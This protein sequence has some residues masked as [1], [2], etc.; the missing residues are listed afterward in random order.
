MMKGVRI[1]FC[2]LLLALRL[3][4]R[5]FANSPQRR[6]LSDL[7]GQRGR[8]AHYRA[9]AKMAGLS[10][11]AGTS[12]SLQVWIRSLRTSVDWTEAPSS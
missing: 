7:Q 9:A 11:L 2:Q 10:R 12:Q 1:D 6:I 8:P 5:G 3:S 4:I